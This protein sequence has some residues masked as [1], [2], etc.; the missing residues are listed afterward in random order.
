MAL[1]LLCHK[2]ASQDPVEKL[3][4]CEDDTSPRAS[5]CALCNT[6]GVTKQEDC[7][8]DGKILQEC[9]DALKAVVYHV[10]A[11]KPQN[12]GSSEETI[13]KNM[14][15]KAIYKAL[16]GH[17]DNNEDSEEGVWGDFA[18]D[19]QKNDG[20]EDDTDEQSNDMATDKR[21]GSV[22]RFPYGKRYGSIFRMPS[23]K[24]YGS[25]FSMPYGKRYGSVFQLPAG[26]RYG[27]VFRLPGGKRYGS[28]F[29]LPSGK[30]YGSVFRLPGGKRYGSVFNLPA[31]KRYG[32]VFRL[33]YGK[34]YGSVF[35]MPIGKRYTS[36][37]Q[38]P[39]S[40]RYGAIL[41][42]PWAK[43]DEN[44]GQD[45]ESDPENDAGPYY[46]DFDESTDEDNDPDTNELDKRYGAIL[47]YPWGDHWKRTVSMSSFP[48]RPH[49]SAV[50]RND[51]IDD[52]DADYPH[53]SQRQNGEREEIVAKRYGLLLGWPWASTGKIRT[54]YYGRY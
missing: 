39:Y 38:D 52:V 47:R 4:T 2:A 26:K 34:R 36:E 5:T 24:R 8:T 23:G 14:V 9:A 45:E 49:E 10:G 44:W 42:F 32:S 11:Q 12:G 7:C 30:R 27:S 17:E 41:R 19:V 40:K 22:F 54:S 50:R 3:G 29:R 35:R 6:F 51:D 48:W 13:Q 1:V 15:T 20:D 43:R 25:V 46:Y 33:P 37:L 21:Y 53:N 18:S 31:G 28:V 16:R